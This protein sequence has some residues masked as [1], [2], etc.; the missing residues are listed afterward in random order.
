MLT[1]PDSHVCLV[2]FA[3]YLLQQD[4]G[5]SHINL[6]NNIVYATKCAG[7]HQHYGMANYFHNNVFADVNTMQCDGAIR[8]VHRNAKRYDAV[9]D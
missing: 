3:S 9:C 1:L 8:C 4:E 6:I 2:S 5:S 7:L